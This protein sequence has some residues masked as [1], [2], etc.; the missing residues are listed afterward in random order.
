MN[1]T[2]RNIIYKLVLVIMTLISLLLTSCNAGDDISTSGHHTSSDRVFIESEYITVSYPKEYE[3]KLTIN[4]VVQDGIS[5]VI[6]NAPVGEENRELFRIYFNDDSKGTLCGYITHGADEIPV[7][8][9]VC[10]YEADIFKNEDMKKDYYSLMEVFE[11]VIDSIYSNPQ[12]RTEKRETPVGVKDV[13]AKYW[14]VTIPD[15]V[16]YEEFES[17][18]AYNVVFYGFVQ[19]ERIDLYSVGFGAMEA[20][21]SIGMFSVAGERHD[22]LVRIYDIPEEYLE[23]ESTRNVIYRMLESVNL[24]VDEIISE[25]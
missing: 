5:V 18:V 24:V 25:A 15:N 6:F 14:K 13:S 23:S 11:S 16:Y 10:E 12:F 2:K 7:S 1:R 17:D 19:N 9:D 22:I 4:E 21:Y 3:G 20:D 8:Y